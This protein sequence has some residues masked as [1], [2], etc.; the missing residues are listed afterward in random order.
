MSFMLQGQL[1]RRLKNVQRDGK[2]DRGTAKQETNESKQQ[3]TAEKKL[4]AQ[5][6]LVHLSCRL[7]VGS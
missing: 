7:G 5:P 6:T 2:Q 3:A 1:L 4:R